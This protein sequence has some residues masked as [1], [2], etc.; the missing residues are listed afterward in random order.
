MKG[1][2][3]RQTIIT[4]YTDIWYCNRS[5]SNK[6]IS[7]YIL[8]RLKTTC[9]PKK[10]DRT[11]EWH[12]AYK[13]WKSNCTE[14]SYRRLRAGS[15]LGKIGRVFM[16]KKWNCSELKGMCATKV[17]MWIHT[18]TP[19]THVHILHTHTHITHTTGR[20][21]VSLLPGCLLKKTH[22]YA[23]NNIIY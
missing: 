16:I 10:L 15:V 20:P 8:C 5:R 17:G 6:K 1:L 3:A 22:S 12:L 4:I 23:F 11:H 19:N 2:R 13:D 18:H 21:V 7:L 14:K 9:M